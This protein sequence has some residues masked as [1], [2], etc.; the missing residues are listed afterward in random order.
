MT[1]GLFVHN[2]FLN[3]HKFT[4]FNTF[5]LDTAKDCGIELRAK[6]NSELLLCMERG[7]N[8]ILG[9]DFEPDFVLYWDKDIRLAQGLE[10]M[11]YRLFNTSKAIETCDDK[12]LTHLVLSQSG[13]PMPR[14]ISCPK[15][16]ENI[17]YTQRE[18]MQT[19]LD[20]LGLPFV[21]KEC[22]GSF[23]KQ[24]YLIHSME[25]FDQLLE[26]S[27]YKPL[28]FQEYIKTSH[29]RDIRIHVVGGA[30]E[31]S[32][33]RFNTSGDFRA[34]VT[35]GGQM[36]PYTPTRAEADLAVRA[37]SIIGLDFAG[38]D[39]LY[40]DHDEPILCEVNSNAHLVNIYD[41]ANINIGFPIFEHIKRTTGHY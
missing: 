9:L 27:D 12:S 6:T 41:C 23:G 24:V 40:G 2:A 36:R 31:A 13:I 34:N 11:G 29:G 39:L 17:G 5:V 8:R 30:V 4:E 16:F 38:V 32:M 28:L 15:T 20:E 22:F 35:A 7:H 19:V 14:T 10:M 37:C 26:R 33:C 3:S 18:F 25:E 21:A 1:K